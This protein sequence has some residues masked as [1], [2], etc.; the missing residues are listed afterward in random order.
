M[1]K[2]ILTIVLM[3]AFQMWAA[4]TLVSVYVNPSNSGNHTET[5]GFCVDKKKRLVL[6]P[7]VCDPLQ[8]PAILINQRPCK[9]VAQDALYGICVVQVEEEEALKN[10][11]EAEF[12]QLDVNQVYD[13]F[14]LN[15]VLNP[16]CVGKNVCVKGSRSKMFETSRKFCVFA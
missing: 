16:A 5:M 9:V 11:E 7:Y 15:K 8:Q 13:I 10:V 4:N 3:M 1:I 6:L 2:K 12:V 14:R